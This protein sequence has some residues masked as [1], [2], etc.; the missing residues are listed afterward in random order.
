MKLQRLAIVA[1]FLSSACLGS[2]E[3]CGGFERGDVLRIQLLELRPDSPSEP[4]EDCH[5]AYGIRD[6]LEL[7]ATLNEFRGGESCTPGIA[8]FSPFGEWT[9]TLVPAAGVSDAPVGGRY[10]ASNE[11]CSATL[12]VRLTGVLPTGPG[13]PP[14]TLDLTFMPDTP[15]T[16]P[17][18][19]G[20][21]FA[22]HVDKRR[23]P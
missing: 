8:E 10:V 21:S 11:Q 5:L 17:E 2:D 22:A 16:C 3:P 1:A 4:P 12:E 19:C 15:A 14:A 9:W 13:S 20:V 23:S 7:V 6:G 18:I